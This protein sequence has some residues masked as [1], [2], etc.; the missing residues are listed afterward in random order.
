M[1]PTSGENDDVHEEVES[2]NFLHEE[3]TRTILLAG[4]T[5]YDSRNSVLTGQGSRS[6]VRAR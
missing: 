3:W 6:V 5:L 2:S 1:D 4:T